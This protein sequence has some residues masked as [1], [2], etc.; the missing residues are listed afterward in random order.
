MRYEGKREYMLYSKNITFIQSF[1]TFRK[2]NSFSFYFNHT[3]WVRVQW[4]CPLGVTES[5]GLIVMGWLLCEGLRQQ[6]VHAVLAWGKGNWNLHCRGTL[7]SSGSHS[8]EENIKFWVLSGHT[9][10]SLVKLVEWFILEPELGVS[11]QEKGFQG[12]LWL[13]RWVTKICVDFV[14][15]QTR[16]HLL[17]TKRA[18]RNFSSLES[19]AVNS[20]K[21]NEE[22]REKS[23]WKEKQQR[24]W[25]MTPLS[26]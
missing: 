21:W 18:S 12:L 20:E 22:T 17:S 6:S 8:D 19:Q 25:E 7:V 14:N 2:W 1:Q 23:Q 24:S 11:K 15:S 10:V 3:L 26:L 16:S 4:Q 13:T 9:R 5:E